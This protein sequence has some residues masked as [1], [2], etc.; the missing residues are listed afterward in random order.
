[1][2]K[3]DKVVKPPGGKNMALPVEKKRTLPK[4]M[5]EAA[6]LSPPKSPV[7]AAPAAP[8]RAG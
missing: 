3:E 8:K 1:M 6:K 5:I 4:W 7:K 2:Q